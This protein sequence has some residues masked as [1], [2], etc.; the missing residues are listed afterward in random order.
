[1][2]LGRPSFLRKDASSS[3]TSNQ[4]ASFGQSVDSDE[5]PIQIAQK[6][7]SGYD[8]TPRTETVEQNTE[9]PPDTLMLEGVAM[10]TV[11]VVSTSPRA[12]I[13]LGTHSG[14]EVAVTVLRLFLVPEDRRK[15]GTV[16]CRICRIQALM[17]F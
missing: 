10:D 9:I 11:D 14:K 6:R 16:S 8:A 1:M 2:Y 13:Y 17:M 7:H 12:D 5:S 15:F 4:S 3:R